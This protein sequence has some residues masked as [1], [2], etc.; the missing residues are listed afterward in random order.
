MWGDPEL[1]DS[2]SAVSSGN[3]VGAS[4]DAR[5]SPTP[6]LPSSRFFGAKLQVTF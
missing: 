2:N 3:G 4:N 5:N 6:E 1:S